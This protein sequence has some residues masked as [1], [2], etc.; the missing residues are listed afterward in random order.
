ML[1]LALFPRGASGADDAW[2]ADEVLTQLQEL[3][4]ELSRLRSEVRALRDEV[5]ALKGRA[6]S[7]ATEGGAASIDLGGRPRLGS[8]QAPVAM[9]EFTDFECPF[10]RR[11]QLTTA[12][13]L[14]EAYI[15]TGKVLYVVMDYPLA[16]HAHARGAAV[17][18]RCAGRQDQYWTMHDALFSRT[19]A[20]GP[21]LYRELAA[22]L[23]LDLDRFDACLADAAVRREVEQDLALG[24][25]LG[26]QG[27]PAFFIGPLAGDRLVDG[28]LITGA[29]PYETF[30][31]AIESIR[32]RE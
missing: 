25:R 17:A 13:R 11:H 23:E 21:A 31:E 16:F 7:G 15:D 32:S 30:A 12:G 28:R 8:S 1:V 22:G 3:R 5:S 19:A 14:R 20:L 27:T 10:C 18:A 6:A 2:L 4:V 29:Q 26:V 24:D 9:V